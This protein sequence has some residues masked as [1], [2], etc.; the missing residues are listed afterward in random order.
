MV[1]TVVFCVRGGWVSLDC[2]PNYLQLLFQFGCSSDGW[3]W[4]HNIVLEA[5]SSESWD[6][7][8]K[9]NFKLNKLELKGLES[10]E[11]SDCWYHVRHSESG[12]SPSVVYTP[13]KLAGNWVHWVSKR[14][15]GLLFCS[16]L[17]FAL[18]LIK[19]VILCFLK[20]LSN[21]LPQ[22]CS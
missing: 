1:T 2:F 4:I 9:I 10:S 21:V 20:E 12:P 8:G 6:G 5:A 18:Y 16:G 3:K 19:V 11:K 17:T 14:S 7:G 22:V 15:C 13:I